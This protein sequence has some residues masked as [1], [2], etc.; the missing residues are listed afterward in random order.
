MTLRDGLDLPPGMLSPAMEAYFQRSGARLR[1]E[2]SPPMPRQRAS[3]KA[4]AAFWR[5]DAGALRPVKLERIAV[6]SSQNR[7]YY[8]HRA[9]GGAY[10]GDPVL[11]S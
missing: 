5:P 9:C 3:S 4:F 2:R 7:C 11:M 1:A 10:S 6:A 8:V